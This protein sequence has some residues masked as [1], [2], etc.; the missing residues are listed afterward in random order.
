MAN[1]DG[2]NKDGNGMVPRMVRR[3]PAATLNSTKRW[4]QFDSSIL[5]ERGDSRSRQDAGPGDV[6]DASA[7][8][9]GARKTGSSSTSG[10]PT[11]D[12]GAGNGSGTGNGS[13]KSS[14]KAAKPDRHSGCAAGTVDDNCAGRRITRGSSRR[15]DDDAVA[16][17]LREAAINETDPIMKESSGGI[18]SLQEGG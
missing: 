17:Q 1:K 14:T 5:T 15:K 2:T 12:A 6:D 18:P 13:V 16:R 4:A 8:G 3:A 7:K 10:G 11:A 9:A